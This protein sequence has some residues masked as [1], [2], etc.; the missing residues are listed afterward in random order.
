MVL[1]NTGARVSRCTQI[2]DYR[3]LFFSIVRFYCKVIALKLRTFVLKSRKTFATKFVRDLDV[4]VAL[5][6][7]GVRVRLGCS[8]A[9]GSSLKS[10]PD[11]AQ[12]ASPN[13]RINS[14]VH[15]LCP[16]FQYK[17]AVNSAI[18]VQ[19]PDHKSHFP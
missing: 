13:R 5:V 9:Q 7:D 8:D 16:R 6:G 4:E 3:S 14:A 15:S 2:A 12:R 17:R 19:Y 18:G 11:S 1:Y 10:N